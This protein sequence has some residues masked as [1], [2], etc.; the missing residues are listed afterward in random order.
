MNSGKGIPHHQR[1]HVNERLRFG[2][3]RFAKKLPTPHDGYSVCNGWK[4]ERLP[5]QFFF[6]LCAVS[7]LDAS[8]SKS[9]PGPKAILR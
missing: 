2:R 9:L 6:C 1:I 7:V 3:T 5:G 4:L 8:E